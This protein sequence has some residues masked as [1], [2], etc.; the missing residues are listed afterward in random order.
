V[1]QARQSTTALANLPPGLP[2]RF[3]SVAS[4]CVL[5]TEVDPCKPTVRPNSSPC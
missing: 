3:S 5:R 2:R 4:G 1:G